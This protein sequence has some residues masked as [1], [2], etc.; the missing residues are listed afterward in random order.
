M[1]FSVSCTLVF[2]FSLLLLL[3]TLPSVFFAGH[4]RN[5]GGLP[6]TWYNRSYSGPWTPWSTWWFDCLPSTTWSNCILWVAQCGKCAYRFLK[7]IYSELVLAI[8]V[9]ITEWVQSAHTW[10]YPEALLLCAGDTSWYQGQEDD[11]Q[12]VR[13]LPPFN[14]GQLLNPGGPYMHCF[15][16]TVFLVCPRALSLLS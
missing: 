4:I 9:Q 13:S 15:I 12:N 10:L 5:C 11:G 7:Y 16:C 1:C 3:F 14:T 2:C 8:S 6:L